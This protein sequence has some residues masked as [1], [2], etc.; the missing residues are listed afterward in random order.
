MQFAGVVGAALLSLAVAAAAAK[1]STVFIGVDGSTPVDE[2]AILVLNQPDVPRSG[3]TTQA[4][5]IGTEHSA[6]GT[7]TKNADF[8]V[9]K[10]GRYRITTY[11]ILSRWDSLV[12]TFATLEGGV[13]YSVRCVGRTS[14][15]LRVV[16]EPVQD[17]QK[18]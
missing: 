6:L 15:T 17:A 12:E 2:A 10:P 7:S 13:K 5:F 16:V 3:V 1:T 14:H 8:A 9:V 4:M 11:C 18:L